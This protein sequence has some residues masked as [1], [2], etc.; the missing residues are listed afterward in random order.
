LLGIEFLPQNSGSREGGE[1]RKW[2][3][4][5]SVLSAGCMP[6]RKQRAQVEDEL[7]TIRVKPTRSSEVN[8]TRGCEGHRSSQNC[9]DSIDASD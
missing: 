7:E 5:P 8:L 3:V 2:K 6:V 9:R 1:G 4:L